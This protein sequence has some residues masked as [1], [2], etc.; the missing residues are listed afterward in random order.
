MDAQSTDPLNKNDTVLQIGNV[1]LLYV[2]RSQYADNLTASAT[3]A[4]ETA[5]SLRA[6]T[7]SGGR[8]LYVR[9]SV[10]VADA[11]KV[12]L[13]HADT[14]AIAS[15]TYLIKVDGAGA[16]VFSQNNVALYTIAHGL[17][18]TSSLSCHWSTRANPDTTGAGDALISEF[19]VYNHTA[20][21]YIGE[22][23]Q[24][25]HAVATTNAGW[26]LTVG[27]YWTGVLTLASGQVSACRIGK[28][29][30]TSI[31]FAEDWI[32]ARS[33]HGSV[34]TRVLEPLP[35][36]FAS[37]IGDE[38]EWAGQA[39]VGFIAAHSNAAR[40][41]M[42]SP[43]VN[44][45]YSDARTL[46]ST[47]SPTQ[48]LAGSPGGGRIYQLDVTRLRW[49]PHPGVSHAWVRVHVQSWVVASTAVPIGVRAYA[50]NRPHLGVGPMLD[51]FP[52]PALDFDFVES[53]LTADHGAAGVGVWL[54]LGLLRLPKFVGGAP[55]WNGTLTLCLAH[56]FDPSETSGNDAN[57]RLKIK[58]W[59]VRPVI[60]T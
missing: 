53:T 11:N 44:E 39:N 29:W 17:G 40:G 9:V 28:A 20:A 4:Y 15:H 38:T 37:G 6:L 21:A 5:S 30:H 1:P 49:L 57:A 47:A 31:E 34:L 48:W 27:G 56:A 42:L 58:A 25:S 8:E 10:A 46:T 13:A 33:A 24:V 26:A 3:A 7:G 59:T 16:I 52:T 60:G 50:L 45:V 54:D 12:F 41:R 22:F 2:D 36:T 14:A 32:A 35:L 43:L 23:K 55:N 51:G 18:A 19:A